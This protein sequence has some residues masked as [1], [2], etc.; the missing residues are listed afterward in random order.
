M[1]VGNDAFD[2][3]VA[4]HLAGC[5][6]EMTFSEMTWF[7]NELDDYQSRTGDTS[8]GA[9]KKA[10]A[11]SVMTALDAVD[12][13][14]GDFGVFLDACL[15]VIG[16]VPPFRAHAERMLEERIDRIDGFGNLGCAFG[17]YEDN[18]ATPPKW[19][20]DRAM[21]LL[22]DSSICEID[23]IEEL[24]ELPVAEPVALA[25]YRTRIAS[26]YIVLLLDLAPKNIAFAR[27]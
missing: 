10:L 9:E 25:A 22:A 4:K 5:L 18:G 12:P 1:N 24:A 7:W 8:L 26:L 19:L 11:F 21:I 14:D 13:D 23:Q 2:R 3:A 20:V 15:D 27:A 16:E 6:E 17:A